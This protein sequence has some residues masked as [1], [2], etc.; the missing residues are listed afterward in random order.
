M[1]VLFFAMQI[2]FIVCKYMEF[3]AIL[4]FY[5]SFCV[6]WRLEKTFLSKNVSRGCQKWMKYNNVS[7]LFHYY[8]YSYTK[9]AIFATENTLIPN[10]TMKSTCLLMTMALGFASLAIAQE[11]NAKPEFKYPL[12]IPQSLD[13]VPAVPGVPA[14]Y[15]KA[16]QRP[17][18]NQVGRMAMH[19]HH[20]AYESVEAAQRGVPEASVRYQTLNGQWDFFWQPDADQMLDG[21]YRPG[22]STVGWKS[23]PVPGCWEL[24]GFGDPIYVGG[25]FIWDH[26]AESNPPFVPLK[27]NHVGY[28]RRSVNIPAAWKGQQIVAHFGAAGSCMFL[29]VNGK[30]VGYSEDN[31]L[32]AEFDLT[33][34]VKV[35][36]ENLIAVQV[37]RMCDGHYLEDQDYFRYTGLY[38]DCY[39]YARGLNTRFDDIRVV[40]DLTNDYKDGVLNINATVKGSGQVDFVL[41]DCCGK[42]VAKASS[43]AAALAKGVKIEVP[44]VKPWSAEVP[45]LYQLTATLR[46]GTK[47]IDVIPLKVG[48]RSIEIS[49]K[50]AGV[51]QLLVNGQPIL[52][53]GADRHELDPDGG[54][55]VSR[56][57]MLQDV[58][59]MKKMNINAVRTCH[60]PDDN[61]WYDLCDQY[62]LYVCAEANLESHGMGYGER[63]LAIRDD[64]R[65]GHLERNQR[66]VQRNFNHPSIIIW[67]LGNEAGY[68]PNFEACYDWVKA[69]DASRP[70]Q[71]ERAEKT[72]K[73]DIF[74]PMYYGYRQCEEYC[75]NESGENWR[76][77]EVEPF[78]KPLIQCEYAHAMGNSEGGFRE[79]WE[80]VRKYPK[81]QGGFIWDFV[82]QSIR[83][84]NSKGRQ[85][86][87]YGGDWNEYDAS[88]NN[89]CDNGL[90]APDRTWNP[91]AYEVQYYYQNIWTSYVN[92]S[93]TSDFELN[94]H[95]ENFFRDLSDVLLSWTLIRNGEIIETGVVDA[96]KVSP[97]QETRVKLNVSSSIEQREEYFLNLSYKLRRSEGLLPAGTE[98][99]RQQL[100][101]TD[102]FQAT[103][104][105]LYSKNTSILSDA[106]KVCRLS[107]PVPNVSIAFDPTTGFLCRYVV[108]GVNYLAEGGQLTPNFWRAPTDN[109]FG[110]GLQRRLSV[111]R[112]PELKLT[113]FADETNAQG[114]RVVTAHYDMPAVKAE[115]V[116]A[117]TIDAYGQIDV[118]QQFITHGKAYPTHF[119]RGRRPQEPAADEIL[120]MFRFGMQYPMP[121]Q[122]EQLTYYGRGPI[123]NY[124]DRKDSQF[125]G[126]YESTVTDEFYPYIRPQENGNHCDVRWMQL[127]T[128]NGNKLRIV[129][130]NSD[131]QLLSASALH[132]TQA[133]LDEGDAKRNLHSP[134][135]DPAPLTNVLIDYKQMGLACEN[136]WGAVPQE[137]Y[138]V[139]YQDYTFCFSLIPVK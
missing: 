113:S 31:K 55:V 71:Y 56:E 115:L 63:T 94:I 36:Q 64:F 97:Q 138:L 19:T 34:Y 65:L 14:A 123:E 128:P 26:R 7:R 95:N 114:Q 45:Y 132:Y 6:K 33:K 117:Y 93:S 83:W 52:I 21:F 18:I 22:Y 90:I 69:E 78:D 1:S 24:N 126:I 17:D 50:V 77:H 74:C 8:L 122:F 58:L 136:S 20:F 27:E 105:S 101:V 133:S 79:Y 134:D 110:A 120:P 47:V 40:G 57:R 67:S 103:I 12:E 118:Q 109:D 39:L 70:V 41:A 87:A 54:Y 5:F 137:P 25:G 43:P 38:R 23:I 37:L 108:D 135:I 92:N 15:A 44:A 51:N 139:P 100:Q 89:F 104:N 116:L 88:T 61:Y 48:F 102:P 91:H 53:K 131:G 80:L 112:D 30:F 11:Q 10:L 4:L 72:G 76:T 129:P 119:P 16:W 49:N 106:N 96:L 9:S 60:Y 127:A 85:I 98:I 62:G 124:C 32:E 86:W 81:F 13:E 59:E 125:V 99:A 75:T 68:G 28:Y 42:E 82:D 66:N 29:W 107:K 46:Q 84:T 111:W 121:L 2:V 73:T 130:L 35:G 3:V